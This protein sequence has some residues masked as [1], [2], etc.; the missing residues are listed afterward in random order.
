MLDGPAAALGSRKRAR[1]EPRR[2]RYPR[3]LPKARACPAA[4]VDLVVSSGSTQ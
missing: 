4:K 2:S 1:L 3:G